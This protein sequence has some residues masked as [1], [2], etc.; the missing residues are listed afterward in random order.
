MEHAEYLGASPLRSRH[1]GVFRY[2]GDL[3]GEVIRCRQESFR[4]KAGVA[5]VM[6]IGKGEKREQAYLILLCFPSFCF[7]GVLFTNF[8]TLHQQKDDSVYCSGLEPNQQ[9]L[10]DMPEWGRSFIMWH[11]SGRHWASLMGSPQ[12]IYRRSCTFYGNGPVFIPS[13]T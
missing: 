12:V 9:Y 8:T 3:V 7:T 6:A 4:D 1:G 13:R 10:W 2:A 5:Y 11:I